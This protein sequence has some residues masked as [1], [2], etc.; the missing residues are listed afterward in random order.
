M[1]KLRTIVP[2]VALAALLAPAGCTKKGNTPAVEIVDDDTGPAAPAPSPMPPAAA[3]PAMDPMHVRV[4]TYGLD[5]ILQLVQDSSSR[6][7]PENVIDLRA[8]AQAILLQMG[9]GPAAWRSLNLDGVM[10]V[11]GKLPADGE[12]AADNVTLVGSVP[13][14]DARALIDAVPQTQRPQPLGNGLWELIAE[15]YRVLFKERA[16]ALDFGLDETSLEQAPGLVS[17]GGKGPRIQLM[18]QDF[19][20]EE[21]RLSELLDISS[22]S[23]LGQRLDEIAA[24]ISAAEFTMDAGTDRDVLAM[25]AA[26]GP[27]GKLGLDPVGPPRATSTTLEQKLPGEPVAVMSMPWGN[28][29]LLHKMM[30]KYVPVDEIGAPF[31]AVVRDAMQNTHALLDRVSDDVVF[32]FYMSKSGKATT[33]IAA[34]V[35]DDASAKTS[36]RGISDT[37]VRALTAYKELAGGSAAASFKVNW[38]PESS[39][40][41]LGKADLLSVGVPKDFVKEFDEAS[42]MLTSKNEFE[43]VSQVDGGV[44]FIALGP[45]AREVAGKIGQSAGGNLAS[46]QGLALARSATTGCQFC[47]GVDPAQ[48]ARVVLTVMQRDAENAKQRK[49][50]SAA[51][52]LLDKLKLNSDLG[53]G[54]RVEAERAAVASGIP[55]ALLLPDA[56]SA[57][58]IVKLLEKVEAAEKAE[59]EAEMTRLKKAEGRAPRG[60]GKPSK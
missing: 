12:V 44:A 36:L 13:V 56:K 6:W 28:P 17:Q 2:T 15:D 3:V 9:Y 23:A 31:D 47:V 41:G 33:L 11:E 39:R 30:D 10:V 1:S 58:L 42:F 53:F 7:S 45:G 25:L 50:L 51:I 59:I 24:E 60:K 22:R 54:A 8:Q 20:T 4:M 38:K 27:F 46:D 16:G 18:A 37:I 19:P 48:T 5:D 35:N 57:E 52:K 40:T 32:A 43:I 21:L 29:A 26:K 55:K 34:S 49:E 14:R